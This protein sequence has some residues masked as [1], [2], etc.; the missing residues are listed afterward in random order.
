M[1]LFLIFFSC[2]LADSAKSQLTY[3]TT[4]P[5]SIGIGAENPKNKFEIWNTLTAKGNTGL[6]FSFGNI[7]GTSFIHN[8]SK[9]SIWRTNKNPVMISPNGANTLVIHQTGVTIGNSAIN[10]AFSLNVSGNVHVA[11]KLFIGTTDFSKTTGYKLAVNGA[12][13]FNKV[14]IK[15]YAVWPDY[16][17]EKNYNLLTLPSLE[18]YIKKNKHLPNIPS[19]NDLENKPLDIGNLISLQLQKIEELTLYIIELEKRIKKLER[20]P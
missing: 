8:D 13:L 5:V 11:D 18:A 9:F 1:K 3:S 4:T 20:Q 7:N 6:D 15:N 10:P 16:V 12:G 17:F 2:L 19:K 14:M